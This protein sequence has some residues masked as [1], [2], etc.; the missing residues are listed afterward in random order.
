MAELDIVGVSEVAQMLGVSRQRIHALARDH[1]NNFPKPSATLAAGRIW[2]RKD[3][4]QWAAA[5]G[6]LVF[7]IRPRITTPIVKDTTGRAD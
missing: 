7:A 6:R 1:R 5:Q 3:I 2:L 4:E